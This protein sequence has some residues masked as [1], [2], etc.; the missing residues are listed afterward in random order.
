MVLEVR[1][2]SLLIADDDES[3]RFTLREIFE[4]KGFATLL[5]SN[6]REAIDLIEGH[7]VDCLLLDF[8]MPDLTGL[9]ILQV[10]RQARG[11]L[12]CVLLTADPSQ[13]LLRQAL[14]LQVYTVLTKPVRQELVTTSVHRAL[15]HAG[16]A[17]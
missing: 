11:F 16:R 14:S 1:Q 2:Y 6:G 15:Q 3:C 4:P 7:V 13:Q 10:V 5:A 17:G 12:P 9:E 8:H